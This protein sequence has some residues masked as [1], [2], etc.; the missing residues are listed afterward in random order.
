MKAM[1]IKSSDIPQ[2]DQKTKKKVKRY[3]HLASYTFMDKIFGGHLLSCINCAECD[4][5]IQRV[6]PFL[7]LSL[8]IIENEDSLSNDSNL[9]SLDIDSSIQNL[10]ISKHLLKKQLKAE[11]K[12]AVKEIY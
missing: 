1:N 8:S 2:I 9:N 7:D 12:L 10:K 3:G 11:A 5:L 4:H 6:E